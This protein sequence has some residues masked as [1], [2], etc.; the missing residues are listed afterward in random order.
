M[1]KRPLLTLLLI[2]LYCFVF[3]QSQP[4][5][6]LTG[7]ALRSWLK[8]NWYTGKQQSLG[9]S[10]ARTQ[11]YSFVDVAADNRVYGVYSG[12]SEPKSS[13]TSIGSINCEHT[14]PQS[15]F[16]E[17]EPLRSDIFHLYPTHSTPNS[18]RSNY[19][20]TDIVDTQTRTW[21]GVT[22]SNTLISSGTI[23]STNKD[24]Y[25]ESGTSYFE[26]RED[27]KGNV[28]RSI[29][30]F[31]T[32]YDLS[33]YGKSIE[34]LVLNGDI[35]LLY[36]W[37]LQDPVDD[38]ERQRNDRIEQVQGNRNP[39]IDYPGLVCS[40]WGFDCSLSNIPSL[41][42]DDSKFEH[43]FGL[44]GANDWRS[45]SSFL[46]NAV[47][48]SEIV[49]VAAPSGYK[50][51]T[52]GISY[53]ST[54]SL[55]PVLETLSEE[56]YVK[57]DAKFSDVSGSITVSTPNISNIS[58]SVS[59]ISSLKVF[60]EDFNDCG[61]ISFTPSSV[62]GDQVWD[63]QSFGRTGYSYKMNGYSG[64]AVDNLDWLVS[65]AV[66]LSQVKDPILGFYSDLRYTGPALEV[67]ITTAYTGN[68]QTTNWTKLDPALD[69]DNT[70][71]NTWVYSGDIDLST[72]A[73]SLI[74]LGFKYQ[75]GVVENAAFWAVE[76]VQIAGKTSTAI[77]TGAASSDWGNTNNWLNAQ[78]PIANKDVFVLASD[79]QPV[80]DKELEIGNLIIE[81]NALLTMNSG[82]SLVILGTVSD[83]GTVIVNRN[84]TKSGGYSIVSSPVKDQ[85]FADL[86][87]SIIYGFNGTTF[88]SNLANS[89]DVLVGAG[90]YF[91]SKLDNS[92]E[93]SFS[94]TPNTGTVLSEVHS[95]N[96]ELV[97]NPY[98]APVSIK[99]FLYENRFVIAGAVYFWDDGGVNVGSSRG[100]DYI[101]VNSVGAV[102]TRQ[103]DNKDDQVDG[104]LGISGAENGYIPSVQGVFVEAIS[105]GFVQFTTAMQSASEGI[106]GDENYYRT[107]DFQKIRI[108]VSGDIGYSQTLIGYSDLATSERDLHYDAKRIQKESS[109]AVYTL[110]DSDAY[111]IQG[112]PLPVF[113]QVNTT[114][115]IETS[116]TGSYQLK[117][118]DFQG[119][120]PSNEVVITDM[121]TGEKWVVNSDLNINLNLIAG[122][123]RTFELSYRPVSILE[124]EDFQSFQIQI[125]N[126]KLVMMGISNDL[127]EVAVYQ[128]DGQ[129]VYQS[130][131]QVINRTASLD[132]EP[133]KSTVYVVKAGESELKFLMK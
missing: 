26:P 124:I 82:A 63:C 14:I 88:S 5:S 122:A 27:H 44:V 98:T 67:Y 80:F 51:S 36:Q 92:A 130:E 108:S 126:K 12:Y 129:L 78:L 83:E 17:N 54:V 23:P 3:A 93:V 55:I 22:A 69:E 125:E 68:P 99:D 53:S 131:I 40:A 71:Y 57:Y 46:V 21:Y 109:L 100:G 39:Y 74:R 117:V 47:N 31:F 41:S 73:G 96:F 75:S 42:V 94:G 121:E 4:P 34:S 116:Y 50:V 110:I 62:T 8:D 11:M 132:F 91:L 29:F 84:I 101:T 89:N 107:T 106:N 2:H 19:P 35:E 49:T 72:Y 90:G 86:N 28:A 95:G 128:L 37:H 127:K 120:S 48:L 79:N 87:A 104:L 13:T 58:V 114:I 30:Y 16:N 15:F 18:A 25:S 66:D 112:L 81:E 43:E 32:M 118:D 113:D 85:V 9:Y 123:K 102:G 38:W 20:F 45:I 97:G 52:D 133:K 76:D 59:S 6:N 33:G 70:A 7:E 77:W 115:V 56:V 60:Y 103:P 61:S 105:S 65:E 111:A 10:A 24:F 64:G 119:Y 1:N